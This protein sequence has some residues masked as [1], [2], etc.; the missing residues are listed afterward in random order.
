MYLLTYQCNQSVQ[1]PNTF[2]HT[3]QQVLAFIVDWLV[4][5][6]FPMF[7]VHFIWFIEVSG[8]QSLVLLTHSKGPRGYLSTQ[9]FGAYMGLRGFS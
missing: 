4:K 6:Y 2:L 1:L 9:A 3:R 7:S 5:L 8:A